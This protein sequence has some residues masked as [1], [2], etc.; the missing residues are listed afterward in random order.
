[1]PFCAD[2]GGELHA[3]EVIAP[4]PE[5][6]AARAAV[7]E[8]ETYTAAEI[9]VA[10]INAEKEIKLARIAA[11]T[12]KDE[13]IVEAVVAEAEADATTDAVSPDEPAP[14]PVSVV[15]DADASVEDEPSIPPADEQDAGEPVSAGS[16]KSN[17]WW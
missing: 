4:D 7:G 16:S 9:E 3:C 8:A 15:A 13:A 17:P 5:A 2:C 14:M 11:G 12:Y 10:R 1:M 6:E